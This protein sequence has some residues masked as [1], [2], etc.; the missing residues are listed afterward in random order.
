MKGLYVYGALSMALSFTAGAGIYA[1]LLASGVYPSFF[2][3]SPF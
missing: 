1:I 3:L 2:A